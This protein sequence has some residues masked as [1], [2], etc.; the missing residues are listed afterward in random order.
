[1]SWRPL[2]LFSLECS[3]S[4]LFDEKLKNVGTLEYFQIYILQGLHHK[5]FTAVIT[6]AQQLARAFAFVLGKLTEREG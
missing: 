5:T 6:N 4:P 3:R 1:M 2:A